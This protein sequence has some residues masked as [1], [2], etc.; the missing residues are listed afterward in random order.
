MPKATPAE[1]KKYL[2]LLPETP[3][4]LAAVT[5]GKSETEL[6]A[7]SG[8]KVWS[9]VETLAHLRACEE[10]WSYSIYAMLSEEHPTLALPDERRWAKVMG[11]AMEDFAASFQTFTLRRSILTRVLTPL[12]VE[13][14]SRSADI[15]GRN[16]TVFSQVRRMVLHEQEHLSQ[17]ELR[18]TAE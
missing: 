14:W 1:I 3:R 8:P 5:N 17:I 6:T 13:G 12:T 16:H 11:Y 18:L 10:L 7:K 15:S 4:R 2:A 9:V